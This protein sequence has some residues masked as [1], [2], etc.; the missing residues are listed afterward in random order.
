MPRAAIST[1]SRTAYGSCYAPAL[2][3]AWHEHGEAS[4]RYEILE[5]VTDE[6]PLLIDLRLKERSAHWLAALNAAPVVG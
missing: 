2:Q 4:F 3:D 5:E 1:G 6:N